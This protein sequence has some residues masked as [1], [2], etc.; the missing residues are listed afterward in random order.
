[1]D[2]STTLFM[3]ILNMVF[4]LTPSLDPMFHFML[5]T[6]NEAL[7]N[8]MACRIFRQL[9]FDARRSTYNYTDTVHVPSAIAF[10]DVNLSTTG[11]RRD[12]L[13]GHNSGAAMHPTVNS[14][15]MNMSTAPPMDMKVFPIGSRE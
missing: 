2:D 11:S 10:R 8:S 3:N 6:A 1:M 12:P 13:G 14:M 15:E 5:L 4:I 7:E 9:K